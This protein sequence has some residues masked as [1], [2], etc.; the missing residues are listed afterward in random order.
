VVIVA[1][2]ASGIRERAR[3]SRGSPDR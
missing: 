2:G 3:R 1:P